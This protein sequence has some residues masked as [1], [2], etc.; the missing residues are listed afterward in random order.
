MMGERKMGKPY[1]CQDPETLEPV[2][3]NVGEQQPRVVDQL[4][5]THLG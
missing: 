1:K 3:F 2:P 5:Q 4:S